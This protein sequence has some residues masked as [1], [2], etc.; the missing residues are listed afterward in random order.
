MKRT[1]CIFVALLTLLSCR[2]D[3]GDRQL[4]SSIEQTWQQC[5]ISLPE[6]GARTERLRDSVRRSSEYVQ[7]KYNL[8]SI[9]LRDKYQ[10]IPSSPDS[11]IQA[12]SYFAKRKN[13]ID[14]ERAYYYLGSAYRDLKD[15]PRA[16]GY[17]L[18]AVDVAS[19]SKTVDSLIWQYSL[20]QLTFLYLMQLL[21]Y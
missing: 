11:A 5:E 4:L 1:C 2:E 14:Q 21:I 7:Q 20:S 10:I 13:A 18:K 8:L 6:A 15:Y 17:F 16:V 9:R 19:Q 12:M 3:K